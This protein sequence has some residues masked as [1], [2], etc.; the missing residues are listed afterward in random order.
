MPKSNREDL[1]RRL[2]G[3]PP[4]A[5]PDP[6]PPAED[7]APVETVAA[8]D[9]FPLDALPEPLR[10]FTAEGATALDVDPSFVALPALAATAGC[11]GNTRLLWLKSDFPVPA[12]LWTAVVAR[13]GSRKSAGFKLATR[14][15]M[16]LQH[17]WIA[18]YRGQED[19]WKEEMRAFER[20]YAQSARAGGQWEMPAPKK[21]AAR[22]IL[23]TNITEESVVEILEENPR[24]IL[25]PREELAGWIAGMSKYTSGVRDTSTWLELYEAGTFVVDRKQAEK[26]IR[27]VRRASCSITGTATPGTLL[28]SL[29][30]E[31]MDAGVGGRFNYAHPPEREIRWTDAELDPR[32]KG[33]YHRLLDALMELDFD[34]A[35]GDLLPVE[36]R[37]GRDAANKYQAWFVRFGR[38]AV[39]SENNDYVR[40]AN[41]KLLGVAGRLAL[42]YHV[43]RYAYRHARGLDFDEGDVAAD[44]VDA[45]CRLADWFAGQNR[46]VYTARTVDADLVADIRKLG[47]Q[48][49]VREL[50]RAGKF[51]TADAATAFLDG[52]VKARKG[53][54]KKDKQKRYFFLYPG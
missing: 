42:L 52:L 8:W 23:S 53:E 20:Q 40:D 21:P 28:R 50:M 27:S 19:E 30:P 16:E 25:I 2:L 43:C 41:S 44:A 24:G 7:D 46:R 38:D 48:A 54:W 12:I 35:G 31:Y 26:R 51:K 6:P 33:E 49:T 32:V 10:T 39:S 47:D 14:H 15:L 5:A 1:L 34:R 18:A 36:H 4:A 3:A 22:R 29:T 37:L 13:S 45:G 9:P 11:I 17:N